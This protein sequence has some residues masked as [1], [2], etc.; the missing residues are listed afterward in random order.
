MN[1]ELKRQIVAGGT[2]STVCFYFTVI[3]TYAGVFSGIVP[4]YENR[5]GLSEETMSYELFVLVAGGMTSIFGM[6]YICDKYGSAAGCDLPG[7]LIA[8]VF[9]FLMAMPNAY[10]V[11][12]FGYIYGFLAGGIEIAISSQAVLYEQALGSSAMGTFHACYA[13]G[14]M[15]GSLV[16]GLL[17][18]EGGSPFAI[19]LI[20]STAVFL[21]GIYFRRGLISFDVEQFLTDEQDV[22]HG[23]HEL[24]STNSDHGNGDEGGVYIYGDRVGYEGGGD[25]EME[26]AMRNDHN[27]VAASLRKRT[28]SI[29]TAECTSG[30]NSDIYAEGG[31]I[32]SP[33]HKDCNDDLESPISIK[34]DILLLD[35]T[36]TT[37]LSNNPYGISSRAQMVVLT[38][39][40]TVSWCSEGSI[41]DWSALYNT[42]VLGV[43]KAQSTTAFAIFQGC[44]V[45]GRLVNDIVIDK[46]ISRSNLVIFSG[47]IG[48][49]GVL[50]V[51]GAAYVSAEYGFLLSTAGFV[52]C[53]LGVSPLWSISTSGAAL[54]EGYDT[55]CTCNLN[56]CCISHKCHSCLCLPAFM[57]AP[58]STNPPPSYMHRQQMHFLL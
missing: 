51:V 10:D 45:V 21:G 38:I 28:C 48:S 4:A 47:I 34:D 2:K 40:S 31:H 35:E 26:M 3:G 58:A 1:V 52:I 33:I 25:G 11:S 37:I 42:K 27:N 6:Q 32:S 17:T 16:T 8:V 5:Y 22:R 15:V 57:C 54:I 44:L 13:V 50:A 36:A 12:I 55:T 29:D 19:C 56:V 23:G 30:D 43:S 24:I 41:G 9:P 7:L 46:Y 18:L 14:A 49:L 20:V 39:V 53:G